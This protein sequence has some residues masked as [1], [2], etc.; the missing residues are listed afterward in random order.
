MPSVQAGLASQRRELRSA[1]T[2][3]HF[4]STRPSIVPSSRCPVDKNTLTR[5]DGLFCK[6]LTICL[7]PSA[8]FGYRLHGWPTA[9]PASAGTLHLGLRHAG[10]GPCFQATADVNNLAVRLLLVRV[11][12]RRL[13]LSPAICEGQSDQEQRHKHGC[14]DFHPYGDHVLHSFSL[15]GQRWNSVAQDS[16]SAV[17]QTPRGQGVPPKVA[18]FNI[19]LRG[20]LYS[21]LK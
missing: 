21:H 4:F 12:I 15:R 16:A 5:A 10:T 14:D 20:F 2:G 9:G 6:R 11:G 17:S 7:S 8:V 3:F 19:H 13:I 18:A 1:S